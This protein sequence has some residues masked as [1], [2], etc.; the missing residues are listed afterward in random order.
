MK[1]LIKKYKKVILL[2][3]LLL[4]GFILRIYFVEKVI[5]GDL[6][7]YVEWGKGILTSGFADHYT[8]GGWYITPPVYA[9]FSQIIFAGLYWLFDHK[10]VLAQLHNVIK[11][12]PSIFIVY[13]YK[14]GDILVM[15]LPGI[16]C[17]LGL[18]IVIYKIILELTND[19]KRAI[20]GLILFLFNPVTIF[21]SGAWGQTD[22]VV[23]LLGLSSFLALNS[24]N[25]LLSIPLLFLS[26]YFKPSW[27]V[28]L[29]FYLYLL[30]I[31]KPHLSSIIKGLIIALLLFLVTTIPFANGNLISFSK[32]LFK[33][34][35][36]LPSGAKASISAFN[37]QT[38][39]FKIDRDFGSAKLLGITANTIGTAFYVLINLFTFYVVHK[40][41][42]KT[43]GLIIGLF[44][45]GIGGFLFM[46]TMLERYFFPAF[47]PLIILM[48]V[49]PKL[50]IGLVI[51][52][53]ILFANLIWS[54]YRRGSDEID[55]P[56]TN[57]NFLLIRVL[58]TVQTS[59]YLFALSMLKSKR[60]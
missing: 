50:L 23:A 14:Y 56:F 43:T 34:R 2:F 26:L 12:P 35:L 20:L 51:M 60:E 6:L 58:S 4:A 54:F 47:A 16:L 36:P 49:K 5:V 8:R 37:F 46:S 7:A 17:D 42:N 1:E 39:F 33:E 11:I 10:Y 48:V 29:P 55:H 9:P 25:A 53:I 22:S 3:L 21:M 57:N 19:F 27:G 31:R 24:R 32:Y 13:F 18:S 52:N 30:Y 40:Q 44:M 41:K 45:I 38:I 28:F 59:I 15:K